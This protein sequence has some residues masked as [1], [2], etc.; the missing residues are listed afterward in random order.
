MNNVRGI[1]ILEGADGT[2][3]TTLARALCGFYDGLYLHGRY[4]PVN[5]WKYHLAM[6]R[7]AARES[8]RRLV[9]IDRHWLSN[10]IYSRVYKPEDGYGA[11]AR[12]FYR[13][14]FRFGALYVICAPPSYV[15]EENHLRL[16]G[17]RRE[18]YDGRMGEVNDRFLRLWAGEDDVA[19]L[20]D[21]D[22]VDQLTRAGGVGKRNLRWLH[23]D[24]RYYEMQHGLQKICSAIEWK[25]SVLREQSWAPGLGYD[26]QNFAGNAGGKVLLVGD[27]TNDDGRRGVRWPFA[28]GPSAAYLN[29]ALHALRV[30]EDDIAI[31]NAN[32]PSPLAELRLNKR[33]VALGNAAR[34]GIVA[35]GF[36]PDAVIR[37]PQAARRFSYHERTFEPELD[38]ALGPGVGRL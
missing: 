30:D 34:D 32:E 13:I 14:F 17:L 2:G 29:R 4:W 10:A 5:P 7:I 35:A 37:H 25:L 28:A 9:V 20:A 18:L 38:A 22:Y 27:K 12:V 11:A 16:K 1:V 31:V 6:C 36:E 15:V 24:Y 19:P 33:W 3:K 26:L 21:E 8:Q 23:Y